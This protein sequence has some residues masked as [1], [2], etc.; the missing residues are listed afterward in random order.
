M[1]NLTITNKTGMALVFMAG[2]A[3]PLHAVVLLNDTFS[4]GDR[5]NQSLPGS[6]RWVLVG[7]GGD[8]KSSEVSS[9]ALVTTSSATVTVTAAFAG[10]GGH[11]LSIGETLTLTFDFV[12][13]FNGVSSADAFRFGIF[14]SNGSQISSDAN[15]GNGSNASFNQWDGF[16]FWTPYGNPSDSPQAALR[17]RTGTDNILWA[18]GANSTLT[19][20]AYP[21]DTIVNGTTYTGLLSITR[22]TTGL[23]ITGGMG[24]LTL[25]HSVLAS[26]ASFTDTFD[27]ISFFAG[28]SPIGA[29]G[30]FTLDNVTVQITPEPS[31]ALLSGLGVAL[32]ALRRSRTPKNTCQN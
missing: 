32:L 3:A 29:T 17:G 13:N 19:S 15:G 6:A 14:D 23:D 1:K 28:G 30:S 5:T 4:D 24:G 16:S 2:M 9:G 11:S 20:S 10:S 25:T 31:M 8:T 18:S 21:S 27:S 7:G 26:H 22:T 12:A